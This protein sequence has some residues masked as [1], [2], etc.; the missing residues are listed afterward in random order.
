MSGL[1][2][3]GPSERLQ[4]P[5]MLSCLT[6]AGGDR[7]AV[8]DSSGGSLSFAQLENRARS[9]A[10]ALQARGAGPGHRVALIYERTVASY[11][12]LLGIVM[13][14]SSYVPLDPQH[15]PAL[16]QAMLDDCRPLLILRPADQFEP[17]PYRRPE[18]DSQDE[19]YLMYTSGS[20]GQPKGV[21]IRQQ[22]LVNLMQSLTRRLELDQ[23]TRVLSVANWCFD[24]SLFDLML[25]V[26]L[27]C[28]LWLSPAES[29]YHPLLLIETI[30]QTRASFM[31]ATPSTWRLVQE[32]G[33]GLRL[34]QTVASGGEPLSEALAEFLYHR[35]ERAWN[36]YGPTESCVWSTAWRIQPGPVLLG[37]PLANTELRITAEQ[38]LQIA[39]LC[40]SPGYWNRPELTREKFVGTAAEPHDIFYRTGDLVRSDE[41]GLHFLGRLD[42]QVKVG[43][44]RLELEGLEILL[45]SHPQIEEAVVCSDRNPE[46]A[47]LTAFYRSH[48]PLQQE[49]LRAFLLERL[50]A[51]AVPVRFTRVTKFPLNS[52][53]KVDRSALLSLR[54]EGD[55]VLTPEQI[56]AQLFGPGLNPGQDLFRDVG[57]TSMQILELCRLLEIH[58]HRD[59]PVALVYQQRTLAKLL[60]HL[61]AGTEGLP[62]LVPLRSGPGQRF[63][64]CHTFTGA[65][66]QSLAEALPE[67][68][69][70]WG[71]APIS[72]ES[73][74]LQLQ[75]EAQLRLLRESGAEAIRLAG[76]SFGALLAFEIARLAYSQ[77]PKVEFI[78]LIDPPPLW[79]WNLPCLP[80]AIQRL[81]EKIPVPSRFFCQ[82]GG[83]MLRLGLLDTLPLEWSKSLLQGFPGFSK[84]TPGVQQLAAWNFLCE[85]RYRPQIYPARLHLLYSPEWRSSQHFWRSRSKGLKSLKIAG[86]H[87]SLI[88]PPLVT[89]TASSL[90]DLWDHNR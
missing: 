35:A 19:A 51:A 59:V 56:G 85:S 61:Q 50:P 33:P 28:Q 82:I 68:W 34:P 24:I 66:P 69:D 60:G 44:M 88:N 17:A 37:S 22:S 57:A 6:F 27:G 18:V 3:R 86:D 40:L 11:A 49:H 16:T 52:R 78:C 4:A 77:G 15:P 26:Y 2:L 72:I 21:P 7:I 41:R 31:Q 63:Y 74:E 8:H 1:I 89:A 54:Q 65:L 13:S 73:S 90:K 32:T 76:Y 42:N 47:S 38:E 10:G 29:N 39:G 62:G 25:P 46:Q 79:N 84:L 23:N 75:A 9:I 12:A 36:L 64:L 67:E 30:E 70:V 53:G 81:L 87:Y 45:A 80:I 58:F 43:G 5:E 55:C 71:L 48:H 83:W 14:G 20:T